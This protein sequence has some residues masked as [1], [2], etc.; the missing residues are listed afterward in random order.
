V[1]SCPPPPVVVKPPPP[2]TRELVTLAVAKAPPQIFREP[3]MAAKSPPKIP[4]EAPS[5][6]A[7]PR[8]PTSRRV[9]QKKRP[10]RRQS[11]RRGKGKTAIART[12]TGENT[13]QKLVPSQREIY[14][15]TSCRA[16]LALE[17]WYERLNELNAYKMRTGHCN[18]PQKW[19]ENSKLGIVGTL[20]VPTQRVFACY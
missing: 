16:K 14:N 19:N 2:L 15:A 18:V 3:V 9:S 12:A 4:Q 5:T 6:L 8:Q 13:S 17:T 1:P 11:Q 20:C 7:K 10:A